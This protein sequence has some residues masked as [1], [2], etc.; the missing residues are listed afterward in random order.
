MEAFIIYNLKV[1]V[2]LAVFYLFY[3]LLLSRETLHR[4]NRVVVL[5]AMMLAFV[6][7]F[8]V[9]TIE[10]EAPVVMDTLAIPV[11]MEPVS[12]LVVPSFSWT[13]ITSPLFILGAVLTLGLT[14][15]SLVRIMRMIHRGRLERLE[16][17]LILSRQPQAIMPFSWM[18]WI[19]I[20]DADYAE[21]GSEIITHE[22]EHIRCGH[23]FD[24]LVTDLMSCLQWFNPAMWLLRAE[25]RAIHEYEADQA[26][27]RSG[28]DEKEYQL[29]L[30]KKAAGRRWYSMANSFN[31]SKLKNRIIMML[32]KRSSMWAGAK[33][34]FVLPLVGLA[35]SAF[36]ETT[37]ASKSEKLPGKQSSQIAPKN[38]RTG[39][40][41]GVIRSN[42]GPLAGATVRLVGTD[43]TAITDAEGR[44][45]LTITKQETLEVICPNYQTVT[46]SVQPNTQV[47][48]SLKHH[49][50]PQQPKLDNKNETKQESYAKSIDGVVTI[51]GVAMDDVVV[52][53]FGDDKSDELDKSLRLIMV[54]G[55][56]ITKAE[57]SQINPANIQSVTVLKDAQSI[58]NYDASGNEA[59]VLITTKQAGKVQVDAD[60]GMEKSVKID[61]NSK[62]KINLKINRKQLKTEKLGL[63]PS[64]KVKSITIKDGDRK[65]QVN[66]TTGTITITNGDS[67]IK[68]D[69]VDIETGLE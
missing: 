40:V 9:L 61:K 60:S 43:N 26:V 13:T 22:R 19:V 29:L 69:G 12:E 15:V 58:Q 21:N 48:I 57:M 36:A 47:A 28:V 4:L 34:L 65:I 1:G 44:F 38:E 27:I 10:R 41:S 14:L 31:N 64:G 23:S 33:A 17:G 24:L 20:S 16:D 52:V 32:R 18:H 3:K 11:V 55:K 25:L 62:G 56:K 59:V 2:C 50:Q 35:L 67:E 49:G 53:G 30:I 51:D 68:V 7:P 37:Y 5:V 8:C 39:T 63:S 45:S 66:G 46:T 42:Q 54:D 6:L